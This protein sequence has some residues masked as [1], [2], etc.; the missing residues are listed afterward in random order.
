[1]RRLGPSYGAT[2]LA[3]A[4]LAAAPEP[5]SES[6]VAW[7]APDANPA[8]YEVRRDDRERFAGRFSGTIRCIPCSSEPP[9]TLMQTVRADRY[10]GKRLRLAGYLKSADVALWAGF[11]MRVD[12][13]TRR[14]VGFDNMNQRAVKGTTPWT[15]YEIV[16]DVPED[17]VQIAFGILLAGGGQ[18]WADE[19]DLTAVDPRVPSTD[20][21]FAPDYVSVEVG[22]G[23]PKEPRNLGF[24]EWGRH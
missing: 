11:W 1:M 24:E 16:L 15:R 14:G 7:A 8:S 20:L 18:L 6:P 19:L 4:L 13:A 2:G 5:T 23:V 10:R 21:G 12:A 3:L 9:A 17:A 22:D